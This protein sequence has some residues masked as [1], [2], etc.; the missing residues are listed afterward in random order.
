M[1]NLNEYTDYEIKAL[2]KF[3]NSLT[4]KRWSKVGL[5]TLLKLIEDELGLK[6]VK[7]FA[8]T[9]GITPQGARK[10]GVIRIDT[11]QLMAVNYDN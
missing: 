8:D 11:L 1:T 7:S 2:C 3:T 4:D 5:V 10:K 6:S 9:K